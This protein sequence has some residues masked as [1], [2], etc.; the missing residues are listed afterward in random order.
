MLD[1]KSNKR[2][3][4]SFSITPKSHIMFMRII[5]MKEKKIGFEAKKLC[6]LLIN[7]TNKSQ[8]DNKDH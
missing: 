4:F 3:N 1:F 7:G 2:I 5:K 6:N 8:S